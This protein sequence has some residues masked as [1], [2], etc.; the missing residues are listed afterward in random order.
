MSQCIVGDHQ[1][2]V[3]LVPR[4]LDRCQQC[5]V[6]R[7]CGQQIEMQ[8]G[9]RGAGG[10]VH[11]ITQAFDLRGNPWLLFVTDMKTQNAI[12]A[13]RPDVAGLPRDINGKQR[14][15]G[16][17]H[18]AG[19]REIRRARVHQRV[20]LGE[21]ATNILQLALLIPLQRCQACLHRLDDGRQLFLRWGRALADQVFI[22]RLHF[23]VGI[24]N[25]F[26]QCRQFGGACGS[27]QCRT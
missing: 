10:Q 23:I 25:F 12:R 21:I 17:K 14:L 26:N 1:Q 19:G 24:L 8:V 13:N 5:L 6:Q 2:R 4:R 7:R 15:I 9:G 3:G 16:L 20:V 11:G 22:D 27:A 18:F